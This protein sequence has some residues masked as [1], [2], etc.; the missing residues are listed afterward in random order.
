MSPTKSI[1]NSINRVSGHSKFIGQ[2]NR[3]SSVNSRISVNPRPVI[4][5]D[6]KDIFKRQ[7]GHSRE[8]SSHCYVT[9]LA[10]HV[11][12]IVLL[13]AKK[14]MFW[15]YAVRI[16]ALVKHLKSIWYRSICKYPHGPVC[17]NPMLCA[18]KQMTI[19]FSNGGTRPPPASIGFLDFSPKPFWECWRK[20]LRGEV[21]NCNLET[22]ISIWLACLTGATSLFDSAK[23]HR[24]SQ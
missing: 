19:P 17:V 10:D 2:L 16:V 14:Q 11:F 9:T 13:R 24:S 8:F 4:P 20:T 5:L 3:I 1:S 22:H 7:L 6:E 18:G 21:L 12:D 23:K 15:I